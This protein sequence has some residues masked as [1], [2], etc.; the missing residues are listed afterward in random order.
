MAGNTVGFIGGGRVTHIILGGF[1]EGR[2]NA[3]RG[4][5]Q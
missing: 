1:E 2:K 5:R 4:D 3:G